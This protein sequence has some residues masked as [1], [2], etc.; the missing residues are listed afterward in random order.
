MYCL[1][2]CRVLSVLVLT[3]VILKAIDLTIGLRVD[4]DHKTQGLNVTSHGE[5]GYSI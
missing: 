5:V 4:R 1:Q 2:P 3:F